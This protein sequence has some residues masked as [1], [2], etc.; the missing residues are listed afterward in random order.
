MSLTPNYLE[1]T[2]SAHS[3]AISILSNLITFIWSM[4]FHCGRDSA[5]LHVTK[6]QVP[7]HRHLSKMLRRSSKGGAH[8]KVP[9]KTCFYSFPKKVV[10]TLVEI[11]WNCTWLSA[12]NLLYS[13]LQLF[14]VLLVGP[15][16]YTKQPTLTTCV[17]NLLVKVRK[18]SEQSQTKSI[19]LQYLIKWSMCHDKNLTTYIE[20]HFFEP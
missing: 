1:S 2:G 19:K 9:K 3:N 12:S 10:V 7:S 16:G 17:C 18:S 11:V 8:L 15:A 6:P 5:L 20:C 14:H 13:C 4:C